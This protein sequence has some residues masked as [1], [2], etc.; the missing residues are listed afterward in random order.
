MVSR[1]LNHFDEVNEKRQFFNFYF[2]LYSYVKS[3]YLF[4][5]KYLICK[6]ENK[7][8]NNQNRD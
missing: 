5:N 1:K 2:L 6:I 4:F 7:I 8:I 3:F